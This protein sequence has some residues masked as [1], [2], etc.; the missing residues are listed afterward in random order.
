[1]VGTWHTPWGLQVHLLMERDLRIPYGGLFRGSRAALGTLP[2]VWGLPGSLL[3]S[4]HLKTFPYREPT[5]FS[6]GLTTGP[7]SVLSNYKSSTSF[8]CHMPAAGTCDGALPSPLGLLCSPNL[9]FRLVGVCRS[10]L[11]LPC[12]TPSP[13]TSFNPSETGLGLASAPS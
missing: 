9:S 3:C 2:W 11:T 6:L 10:L 4:R 5:S 8:L 12:S 7:D 1:M 13:C